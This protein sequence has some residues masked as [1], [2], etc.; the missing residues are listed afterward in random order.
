MGRSE[1]IGIFV[2]PL[3]SFSNVMHALNLLCRSLESNSFLNGSIPATWA[4]L[5]NLERIYWDQNSLTGTLPT[6]MSE[7]TQLQIL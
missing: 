4:T 6:W 2:S 1:T 7:L 5:T 3:C